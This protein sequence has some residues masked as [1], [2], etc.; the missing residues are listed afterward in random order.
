[1]ALAPRKVDKL[2]VGACSQNLAIAIGKFTGQVAES[3]DFGR[4]HK[5][6]V[7]GIEKHQL[8]LAFVGLVADIRKS[9]IKLGTDRSLQ[10]VFRKLRSEERRV[11]KEC[12]S[13]GWT[14]QWRRSRRR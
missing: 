10:I 14:D 12:R 13:R 5:G 1:M 8:P 3:L 11:G 2:R 9:G 7:L 6:E 4:A